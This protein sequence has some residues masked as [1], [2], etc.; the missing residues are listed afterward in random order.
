MSKFAQKKFI[1][2]LKNYEYSK[3]VRQKFRMSKNCQGKIQI[4]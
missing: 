1:V 4:V 2:F 3:I